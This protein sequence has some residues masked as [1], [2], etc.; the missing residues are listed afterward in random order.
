MNAEKLLNEKPGRFDLRWRMFGTYVRVKPMFWIFMGIFGYVGT[1]MGQKGWIAVVMF[2]LAGFLSVMVH[3][4][5]HI[6]AGRIF[7]FPGVIVLHMLGG[8]AIGEYGR[9]KP[10]QRIVIAFAEARLPGAALYLLVCVSAPWYVS[11]LQPRLGRFYPEVLNA[12]NSLYNFLIFMGLFW[13]V[14]NLLPVLPQDGGMIMKDL[15]YMILGNRGE[16]LAYF[17]SF[18]SALGLIYYLWVSSDDPTYT[19]VDRFF[20]LAYPPT[21]RG[22]RGK[23]EPRFAMVMYGFLAFQSFMAMIRRAPSPEHSQATGDGEN[24]QEHPDENRGS[25]RLAWPAADGRSRP[26]DRRRSA[27]ASTTILHCGDL[28]DADTAAMLPAGTHVVLGNCDTDRDEI[29]AA[30]KQAGCVSHG[31]WGHLDLAGKSLAFTHGHRSVMRDL[32]VSDGT[33]YL[34]ST[35]TR[36][37]ARSASDGAGRAS[38]IRGRSTGPIRRDS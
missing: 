5:G 27:P 36:T 9:A 33:D 4:F 22:S 12:M 3:E 21:F 8:G 16:R 24:R 31:D 10:W 29:E 15:V 14:F 23:M 34:A 13:T 7:G 30:L 6:T 19:S 11:W 17:L 1:G 25:Q 37:S 20:E 35:A 38:S 32:E 2:V 28:D 26:Q 18:A